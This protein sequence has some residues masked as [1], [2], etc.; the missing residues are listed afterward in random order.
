[1]ELNDKISREQE[2]YSYQID[3]LN[4]ALL[5]KDNLINEK[6]EIVKIL[7]GKNDEFLQEI[8][9][10][11]EHRKNL[12]E[13]LDN[14]SKTIQDKVIKTGS[15]YF[16]LSHQSHFQDKTINELDNKIIG[17]EEFYSH[18]IDGLKATLLEKDNAIN[19]KEETIRI[20]KGKNDDFIQEIN[21]LQEQEKNLREMLGNSSETLENKV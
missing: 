7:E 10:L 6:E 15:Y 12:K 9:Q 4:T 19:E 13:M 2:S 1:M 8:N 20:G 11:Q 14:Y 5:E 17:Q 21:Q 16:S 18:E 3:G